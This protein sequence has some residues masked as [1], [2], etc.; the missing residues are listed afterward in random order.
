VTRIPGK[1]VL[2]DD[3]THRLPLCLIMI[4]LLLTGFILFMGCTSTVTDS[5]IVRTE[6]G[7]VSGTSSDGIRAYLGI[8]YAAPPTGDLRW[9]P[10]VPA[11]P[12]QGTRPAT[13]YGPACPQVVQSDRSAEGQPGNM[14]E[15]CLYLNVWTPALS[16]DEKR[17]VMVFIHGGSFL[18]GAGSIPLYNGT[19]L[20]KKGVV[21]V[22]LNYRLGP[23]GFL[24]HPALA[25]ESLKNSSGNYGLQDQAA[26]LQWVKKN[27]A[28]FGGDPDRITI[29][30]ESAGATSVL[31][32]L[33]ANDTRG[34][35]RQAI[36]ESGPLWTNGSALNIISSKAEAEQ[37]GI[38][39]AK[40]LGYEGPDAI[41]N[42]R[43]LDAWTLVNATPDPASAFWKV[44]TL[45]F[46]PTVDGLL[47]REDPEKIFFEKRQNPVPLIIG[48][49]TNE[50][51]TLAANTGMNVTQYNTYIRSRFGEYAPEVLKKYPATTTEEVQ[52]QMG[53]IMTDVDFSAAAKFVAGSQSQLNPNTYLY[54]FSYVMLP[55]SSLGA[56]HGEE[57]FFVFRPS[58]I[59]PDPAGARVSDMMMDTWVR[60]AKNGDPAGG[61][62]TWPQYT[63]EKGQYLDIGINPVVN[64]GY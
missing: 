5:S 44:H 19:S 37:Y 32:H 2:V 59:V 1:T 24:A 58:S 25:N 7:P 3:V 13:A 63:R 20:A 51:S 14:S 46:K 22:N 45:R 9:R 35:Y 21:L 33:A 41:R 16:P 29:F 64:M 56:F 8:P 36:V 31:V 57:L 49:N 4:V 48:T 47:I 34:L 61:N 15:D 26:A 39:Y 17:P 12:W 6:S 60:F 50:D 18:Q 55:D 11:Q 27:I 23:L 40:S 38:E 42:M 10:P 30:G 54:R 28:G 62:V 53:R 52:Q 43:S